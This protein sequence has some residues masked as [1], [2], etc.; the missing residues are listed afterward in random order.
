MKLVSFL[1]FTFLSITYLC[2]AEL[3]E[4]DT[5]QVILHYCNRPDTLVVFDIDNTLAHQKTECGRDEWFSHLVSQKEAQGYSHLEALYSTLPLFCYAQ[6]NSPLTLLE[7]ETPALFDYLHSHHIHTLGLTSRSLFLSERTY[8]Q[9]YNL[10]ITFQLPLTT[11]NE[12]VMLMDYPCLYQHAI[13]FTGNNDKGDTLL[14]FCKKINY[15][16]QQIIFIDDK[17]HHVESVH[18]TVQNHNISCIAIRYS[19]SDSYV[20]HFNPIQAKKELAVL[21]DKN[22]CAVP[23]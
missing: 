4:S 19:G 16:P 14:Q 9:L 17:M 1:T 23:I 22:R 12:L 15:Y 3:I 10:G 11:M 13:L 18:R 2:Y 8:E 6:F 21:L 7:T 5:L 20:T